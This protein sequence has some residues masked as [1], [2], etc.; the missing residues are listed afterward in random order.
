MISFRQADILDTLRKHNSVV[1]EATLWELNQ[2]D[3][4][5]VTPISAQISNVS[6]VNKM[7]YAT[8]IA[9][10]V[11]RGFNDC[12]RNAFGAANYIIR[13][14]YEDIPFKEFVVDIFVPELYEYIDDVVGGTYTENDGKITIY[15]EIEMKQ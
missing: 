4:I 7:K 13:K 3:M 8:K 9:S 6:N 15:L 12:L 11:E 10:Q 14:K 5:G 1:F 2:K